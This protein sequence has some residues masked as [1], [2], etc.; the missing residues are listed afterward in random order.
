V[1]EDLDQVAWSS[2][3]EELR[4]KITD[5]LKQ[6]RESAAAGAGAT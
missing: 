1:Y 5:T 3:L 6:L 4:F 2:D